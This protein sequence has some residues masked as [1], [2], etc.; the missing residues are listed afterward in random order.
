VLDL[1]T[2]L[3]KDFQSFTSELG[4]VSG[5]PLEVRTHYLELQEEN[6]RALQHNTE[7]QTESAEIRK[8]IA[9]L[10]VQVVSDGVNHTIFSLSISLC[11][12]LLSLITML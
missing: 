4:R 10:K 5:Q 8:E 11:S 9:D 7:L 12:S 6:A 1:V 2:D 3:H